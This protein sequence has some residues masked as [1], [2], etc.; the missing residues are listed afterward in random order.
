MD[1]NEEFLS[2]FFPGS[3]TPLTIDSIKREQEDESADWDLKPFIFTVKG[4]EMQFFP[5]G[6]L[7]L[8]LGNRSTNTLRAWEKEGILPKS[9][10]VKP[11]RDPRGRRRMYTRAMVEGLVKIAREEGVLWPHKGVKVGRTQFTARAVELF[12]QLNRTT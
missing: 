2:K 10:Y 6:A 1:S 12:Q 4:K 11:S 3:T 5:I 8:A 9:V 7:A